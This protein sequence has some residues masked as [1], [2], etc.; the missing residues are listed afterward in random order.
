MPN[1]IKL[2]KL[3]TISNIL[4]NNDCIICSVIDISARYMY[5]IR[6]NLILEN[7]NLFFIKRNILLFYFCKNINID[8]CKNI[9]IIYC[10]KN[11]IFN[12]YNNVFIPIMCCYCGNTM[13][14]VHKIVHRILNIKDALYFLCRILLY[15]IFILAKLL[16][17]CCNKHVI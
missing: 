2:E 12:S 4:N 14:I 1:K 17:V 11:I 9:C 6:K 15:N 5:L 10:N 8:V 3:N 13:K 16:L 7:N